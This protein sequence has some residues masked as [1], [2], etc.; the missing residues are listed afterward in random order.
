MFKSSVTHAKEEKKKN[1]KDEDLQ[2]KLEIPEAE[3]HITER[4][5]EMFNLPE[6][7]D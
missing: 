3:Y 7:E 4:C 6:A 1:G 5:D 2:E